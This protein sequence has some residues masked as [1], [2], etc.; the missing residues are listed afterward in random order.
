MENSKNLVITLYPEYSFDNNQDSL[1]ELEVTNDNI[2]ITSDLNEYVLS[3]FRFCRDNELLKS[4]N[5]ELYWKTSRPV[6]FKN[7]IDDVLEKGKY[8][9]LI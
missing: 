9:H 6:I 4:K 3:H 2:F 7:E 8:I 1:E 5:S